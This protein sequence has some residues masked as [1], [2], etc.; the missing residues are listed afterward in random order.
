MAAA[1]YIARD[2]LHTD[3]HSVLINIFR[4]HFERDVPSILGD[5]LDLISSHIFA[6]QLAL[7][8]FQHLVV[9]LCFHGVL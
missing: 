3:C 9:I 5:N 4:I 8:H 1:G 2:A 6:G 7:H